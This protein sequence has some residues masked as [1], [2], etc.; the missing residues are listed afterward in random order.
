[1]TPLKSNQ[2]DKQ[3]KTKQTDIWWE[4]A[5]MTETE[6]EKNSSLAA[7]LYECVCESLIY[8]ACKI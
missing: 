3:N 7:C 8:W 1:M 5:M 6:S 4:R 2:T